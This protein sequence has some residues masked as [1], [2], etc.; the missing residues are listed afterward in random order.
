MLN[1]NSKCD[2][3]YTWQYNQQVGIVIVNML[4]FTSNHHQ[5]TVSKYSLIKLL[6]C[7]QTVKHLFFKRD[8]SV[9]KF[10]STE[11]PHGTPR[12]LIGQHELLVISPTTLPCK[13]KLCDG[14]MGQVEIRLSNLQLH[15]VFDSTHLLKPYP[16]QTLCSP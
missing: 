4:A 3:P 12:I 9:V 13:Q 2:K 16:M 7:L 6:V 11:I 15:N 10:R 5:I 1:K 14:S 8:R